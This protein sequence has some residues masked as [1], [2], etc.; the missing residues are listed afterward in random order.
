MNQMK[1][2]NILVLG[3]SILA[4]ITYDSESNKYHFTKDNCIDILNNTTDYQFDNCSKFGL[5]SKKA[6]KMLPSFLDKYPNVKYALIELGGNDCDFDWKNIS[7][8]P[9]KDHLPN[10][11]NKEYINN[12][13]EILK[14]LQSRNI[15]PI[16]ENLHPINSSKYFN[17][18]SKTLNGDKIL[19]WLK[20]VSLIYRYQES[21]NDSLLNL[22]Y[23]LRIRVLDIRESLLTIHNYEDMLC[24]DGIH[25]TELGQEYLSKTIQNKIGDFIYE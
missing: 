23:Q 25:L 8:D 17:F 21:Y 7:L 24:E 16:I 14:L 6:L 9:L 2:T 4:G 12:I 3:D 22:A 20:D 18:L 19:S 13:Q 1:S 5:T 10:V 11:T 15:Q